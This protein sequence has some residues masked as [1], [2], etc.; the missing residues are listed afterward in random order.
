MFPIYVEKHYL[1]DDLTLQHQ[2][3][4][5]YNV[6]AVSMS[7]CKFCPHI[8]YNL[9]DGVNYHT[10][11]DWRTTVRETAESHRSAGEDCSNGMENTS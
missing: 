6:L 11:L 8:I 2:N 9:T 5:A 3:N 4:K 1:A 10:E 7:G